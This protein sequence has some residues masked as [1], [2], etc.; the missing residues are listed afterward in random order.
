[1]KTLMA[2]GAGANQVTLLKQARKLDDVRVIAVDKDPKAEGIQYADIYQKY[3]IKEYDRL[4]KIAAMYNIDGV[5]APCAD[6]GLETAGR[7]VS[8]LGLKG[9]NHLAIKLSTNKKLFH[10]VMRDEGINVPEIWEDIHEPLL[11]MIVKPVDGVGSQGV[12]KIESFYDKPHPYEMVEKAK[13]YSASGKVVIQQYIKGTVFNV[14]MLLQNGEV[15]YF[16]IHD[17]LFDKDKQNFGVDTFLFPSTY[18][19]QGYSWKILRICTKVCNVLGIKDG[20]VAVEGIM[21]KDKVF[22]LEVNPRM[23]GGRHMEVHSLTT[24]YNWFKD[25]INV[26]L[27][28]SV[29]THGGNVQCR[30]NAHAWVM[31]GSDKGGRIKHIQGGDEA[32]HVWFSKEIG[33]VVKP[34]NSIESST[35]Q[36]ILIFYV[37][38]ERREDVLSKA[39]EIKQT[40]LIEVE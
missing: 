1:M 29:P 28:N 25:G 37:E 39:K 12:Y 10:D 8:A 6:A 5:I 2:L 21:Q 27:G 32:D 23:S 22:I 36:T 4:L 26:L 35:D 17:E 40:I 20:N 19:L 31:V 33:D 30:A 24:D 14:D 16:T 34:F 13:E 11:P 3:S 9:P 7:I 15:V 18:S 38:G